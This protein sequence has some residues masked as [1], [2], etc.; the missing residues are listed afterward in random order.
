MRPEVGVTYTLL[1]DEAL[2]RFSGC[3]VHVVDGPRDSEILHQERWAVKS[4]ANRGEWDWIYTY[5]FVGAT[6]KKP[7]M[8]G[9]ERLARAML[10]FHG[11]WD[12]ERARMWMELTGT[13]AC[14]RAVLCDL[15][16][17]VRDEEAAARKRREAAL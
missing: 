6:V 3:E 4:A 11:G 2:G 8:T 17:V 12:T 16:L 14:T 15:A 5:M 10:L 13:S 1:A 9:A 7:G